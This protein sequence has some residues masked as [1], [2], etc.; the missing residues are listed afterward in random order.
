MKSYA[1]FLVLLHFQFCHSVVFDSL[2]PHGLQHARLPCLSPS[3]IV[4]SNSCPLSRWCH[5]VISSS[6]APFSICLHLSDHQ[7]LFQWVSSSHQV[8][9]LLE[10]QHQSLQW[11]IRIDFLQD[12][13]VWSPC[14]PGDS[15]ESSSTPQFKALIL[16]HSAYL[17]RLLIDCIS[18]FF[19]FIL[20]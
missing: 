1:L 18:P 12:W 11:I 16:Q 9:K 17:P 13:L 6:V 20:Y 4:C 19:L 8:T 7:G 2:R 14:S 5:P 10:L 15:Q 3:P